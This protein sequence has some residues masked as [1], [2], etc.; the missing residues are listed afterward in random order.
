MRWALFDEISALST[1]GKLQGV[2]DTS[3]DIELDRPDAVVSAI[4]D[5]LY[6][7]EH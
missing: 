7:S 6:A 5:V 4:R 1:R 2:A 3:H